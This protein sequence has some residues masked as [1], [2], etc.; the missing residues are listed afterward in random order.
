MQL[1]NKTGEAKM[2]NDRPDW[3]HYIDLFAFQP[4]NQTVMMLIQVRS[5]LPEMEAGSAS[6]LLELFQPKNQTVMML[7]QVRRLL[8]EME[9][10]SASCPQGL[11]QDLLVDACYLELLWWR[12]S[13]HEKQNLIERKADVKLV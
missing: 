11:L 3:W 4:K 1:N 7:I 5:L 9:A 2:S 8:P 12:L 13:Q 10:G 6:Y